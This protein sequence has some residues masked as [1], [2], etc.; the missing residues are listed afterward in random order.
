MSEALPAVYYAKA[1]HI[2]LIRRVLIDFVDGLVL[3]IAWIVAY[4]AF[5]AIGFRSQGA[6]PAFLGVV[7]GISFLYLVLLKRVGRTLGY[8]LF[9][10]QLVSV[11][12]HK[13]SIWS[14]VL[15][16]LFV[17]IGPGNTLLDLVWLGGDPHHQ[18]IRDKV[19]YTY[20][21]RR[22]SRPAGQ[23]HIRYVQVDLLGYQLILPDVARDA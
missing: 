7:M 19:A 5:V 13:P 12:G 23:G 2:G 15:R 1:D 14:L 16:S 10:A 20:V 3:L 9:G 11:Y 17:F 18:A 6:A 4:L 8:V 22:G 21:V